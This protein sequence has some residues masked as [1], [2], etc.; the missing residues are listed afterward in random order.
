MDAMSIVRAIWRSRWLSNKAN[1][2]W[3]ATLFTILFTFHV[4]WHFLALFYVCI[5]DVCSTFHYVHANTVYKLYIDGYIFI[6]WRAMTPTLNTS[7]FPTNVIV[8]TQFWCDFCTN[9]AILDH[10]PIN[11]ECFVLWSS[12]QTRNLQILI[13]SLQKSILTLVCVRV[14]QYHKSQY[15]EPKWSFVND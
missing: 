9:F 6:P 3:D 5:L 1:I 4:P 10:F 7:P 8:I 15:G 11:D 13:S 14:E 2:P 12:L